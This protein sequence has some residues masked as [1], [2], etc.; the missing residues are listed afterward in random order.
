MLSNERKDTGGD[1]QFSKENVP[2]GLNRICKAFFW[3]W[4][5][6]KACFKNEEAFR[7]EVYV[8]M[9]LGP[10]ALILGDTGLE[11]ALLLCSVLGVM[12]VE[13]LNSAVES[14]VDRISTEIHPLAKIAKDTASA[15][16]LLAIVMATC[17]WGF[18]LVD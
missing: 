12:V 2:S 8:L 4:E 14:V 13:L 11:R 10:A 1:G 9:V 15:A 18:V 5:G 3:S 17:I 6:L 7:T 16:V